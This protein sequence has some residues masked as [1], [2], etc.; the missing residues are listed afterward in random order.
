MGGGGRL[1]L[2]PKQEEMESKEALRYKVQPNFPVKIKLT[3][4]IR[5]R[6]WVA[7]LQLQITLMGPPL[8]REGHGAREQ[9]KNQTGN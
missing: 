4:K 5:V 2:D 8:N 7:N 9:R 6:V 1:S 3:A